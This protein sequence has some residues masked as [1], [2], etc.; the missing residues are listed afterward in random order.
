[1]TGFRWIVA[2]VRALWRRDGVAAEIDEELHFHLASR[3][4]QYERDGL[5]PDAAR[6]KGA[7]ARWPRRDSSR[8]GL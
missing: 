3:I 6:R 5:T 7:G 4:E 1:M 2:R 8:S